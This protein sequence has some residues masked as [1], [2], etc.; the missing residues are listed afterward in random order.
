MEVFS[1]TLSVSGARFYSF[2]VTVYGHVTVTLES[3]TG[4]SDASDPASTVGLGLG[5]P[6]GTDCTT[7]T[8]SAIGAGTDPQLRNTLDPGIYCVRV[9][10]AGTLTEPV[11][12]TVR[13]A[14]P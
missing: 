5:L 14:H 6:R 3:L 9:S 12:F 2:P 11:S 8:V 1:G 10:D 13:I 7:S 4:T